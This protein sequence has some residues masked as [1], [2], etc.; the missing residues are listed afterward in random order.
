MTEVYE[1]NEDID[2]GAKSKKKR[3]QLLRHDAIQNGDDEGEAAGSDWAN[4]GGNS[5]IS[6]SDTDSEMERKY[7]MEQFKKEDERET[8][9]IRLKLIEEQKK[10]MQRKYLQMCKNEKVVPLPIVNKIFEGVLYLDDYKLNFGLC[11]ALGNVL[12]DLGDSIYKLDLRNNGIT[13]S[14][15]AE[16]I[17]GALQNPHIKSI[18]FRNNEFKEESQE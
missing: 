2:Y 5:P 13:D 9:L 11:K 18:C 12:D 15:F 8:E 10:N 16:V 3:K 7:M 14:D 1:K 4:Q 17:K 6:E